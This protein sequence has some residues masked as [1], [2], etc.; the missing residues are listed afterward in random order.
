SYGEGVERV[1]PL[2]SPNIEGIRVV[3]YGRVRRAK[4]YYLRGRTGRA[5]RI[6]EPLPHQAARRKARNA[7]IMKAHE[8][9]AAEAAAAENGEEAA[10]G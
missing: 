8:E 10:E 4:L 3:R 5:A 2:Y 6:P 7:E 1:F 9:A